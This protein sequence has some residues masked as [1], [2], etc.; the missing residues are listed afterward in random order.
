MLHSKVRVSSLFVGVVVI[1]STLSDLDHIL[2]PFIRSW[3]HDFRLPCLILAIVAIAY[4]SRYARA[5]V[6]KCGNG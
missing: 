4:I 6:L 5:R 2:S 3:G 1:G